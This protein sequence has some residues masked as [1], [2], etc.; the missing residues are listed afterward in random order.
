MYFLTKK[1]GKQTYLS[2][3]E[4]LPELS[5]LAE[6]NA[7]LKSAFSELQATLEGKVVVPEDREVIVAIGDELH[8]GKI[9]VYPD[10]GE[11][12]SLLEIKDGKLV[13]SKR[14]VGS[15]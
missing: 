2:K 3:K 6:E 13:K 7:R 14:K 1:N 4:A 9:K 8:R 5:E 11:P 15:L 10:N 12:L